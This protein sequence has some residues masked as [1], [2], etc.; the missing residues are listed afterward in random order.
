MTCLDLV[1]TIDTSLCHLAGGLGRPVWTLLP[2]WCDW[3][4]MLDRSDSPWYPGVMR[5]FRQPRPGAWAEVMQVVAD[6][7]RQLSG[8]QS[9]RFY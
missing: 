9:A 1:V 2:Y 7:V 8:R 4:W 6:E 3:P 5:L